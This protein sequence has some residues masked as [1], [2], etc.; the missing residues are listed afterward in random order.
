MSELGICPAATNKYFDKLNNGEKG[1]RICWAITGTLCGG[2]VQ[3]TF[4]DKY[5]SCVSCD[6]FKKVREEEGEGFVLLEPSQ[7]QRKMDVRWY[8]KFHIK[9]SDLY[10]LN[11]EKARDLIIKCFYEAQKEALTETAENLHLGYSDGEIYGSIVNTIEL[12]FKEADADFFRPTKNSLEK[13]VGVLAEKSY[14]WGTPVDI[15]E[16]NMKHI[17]IVLDLLDE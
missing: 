9:K 10:N 11:P 5:P 12:A 7:E 4:I 14:K 13:V 3:G 17:Q 8:K 6:F 1:G 16:H 15:I 2:E